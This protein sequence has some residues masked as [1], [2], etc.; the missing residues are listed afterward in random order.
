MIYNYI[1]ILESI[2]VVGKI[3]K[4]KEIKENIIQGKIISLLYFLSKN[5]IICNK[6][7]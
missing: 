2:I 5:N 1:K 4:I 7:K 6:T 3:G